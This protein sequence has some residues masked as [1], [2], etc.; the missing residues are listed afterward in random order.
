MIEPFVEKAR[1]FTMTLT[2]QRGIKQPLP[3]AGKRWPRGR[4][5]SSAMT[6][7]AALRK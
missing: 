4:Q 2:Q 3:A 1:L 6:L 7:T 5:R